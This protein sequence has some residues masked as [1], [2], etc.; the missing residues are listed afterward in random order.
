MQQALIKLKNGTEYLTPVD[1]LD[2]VKRM[3]AGQY[4]DIE[5][6]DYEEAIEEDEEVEVVEKTKNKGGRPKKATN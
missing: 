6:P 2:N 5:F 1:N 4:N 3:L